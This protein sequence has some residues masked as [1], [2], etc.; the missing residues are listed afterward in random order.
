M[1]LVTMML[2]YAVDGGAMEGAVDDD[3]SDG[4]EVGVEA[5]FYIFLSLRPRHD[6]SMIRS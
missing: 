5:L 3:A 6:T 4:A 2:I 1:M